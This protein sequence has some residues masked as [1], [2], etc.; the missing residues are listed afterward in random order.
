MNRPRSAKRS[1]EPASPRRTGLRI[2]RPAAAPD[3]TATARALAGARD[4]WSALRTRAAQLL[5]ADA[6]GSPAAP[7]IRPS[8]VG[9]DRVL[10]GAV[11]VLVAFGMVMVFS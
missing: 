10:V 5:R 2:E 9:V 7:M 1:P 11:L 8:E 4:L 3:P 6:V